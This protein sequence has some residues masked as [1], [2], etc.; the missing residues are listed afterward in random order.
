[1]GKLTSSDVVE[2]ENQLRGARESLLRAIDQQFL[3]RE[4]D[5]RRLLYEHFAAGD[6]PL[7]PDLLSDLD[8][9]LVECCFRELN[10]VDEALKRI[11]YGVVGVCTECGGYIQPDRLRAEPTAQTCSTCQ[12]RI[13]AN[14]RRTMSHAG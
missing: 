12:E 14:L 5:E 11:D 2:L 7:D 1:M 9:P 13:D 8:V 10:A 6:T 3:G 4:A